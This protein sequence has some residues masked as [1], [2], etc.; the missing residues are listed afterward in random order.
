MPVGLLVHNV[1]KGT[2]ITLVRLTMQRSASP[3]IMMCM[4]S[5]II[6][7]MRL[8]TYKKSRAAELLLRLHQI[9]DVKAGRIVAQIKEAERAGF[10]NIQ[11]AGKL[12]DNVFG[13]EPNGFH[14][15]SGRAN[16]SV[17]KN[18]KGK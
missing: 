6:I 5:C 8:L 18:L 12:W 15:D 11:L 14:F 10:H 3:V 2:Y 7:G 16:I 9:N 4:S 13:Y 1:T 17:E